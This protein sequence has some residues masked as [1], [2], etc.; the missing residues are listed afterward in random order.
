[1]I[2]LTPEKI[3]LLHQFLMKETGGLDGLRDEALFDSSVQS[4]VS[5]THLPPH[6]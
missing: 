3:L 4:A 1:M 5:Y 6:K 2:L